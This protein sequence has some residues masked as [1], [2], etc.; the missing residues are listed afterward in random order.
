VLFTGRDFVIIDFEGEPATSLSQRRIKRSPLRD[1]A[2]MLRSFHYAAYT[3]LSEHVVQN[4]VQDEAE[5][6]PALVGGARFWT[7]WVSAAFLESYLA[8][9]G[10]QL[11]PEGR[12]ASEV[13]LRAFL[14]EKAAYEV[15]YE[16]NN[17]PDWVS[18][19]LRGML[20]LLE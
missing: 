10:D 8:V 13:L 6:M 2:G 18:V 20:H 1:V 9:A 4:N 3:G 16:L 7:S 12:D 15:S 17:R 19:P 11:L 5:V 14:L